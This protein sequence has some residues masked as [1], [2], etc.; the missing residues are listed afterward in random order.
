MTGLIRLTIKKTILLCTLFLC[1]LLS[2][3]CSSLLKPITPIPRSD[4]YHH[5]IIVPLFKPLRI[6]SKQNQQKIN[7]LLILS[8][9][10]IN[11]QISI[12]QSLSHLLATLPKTINYKQTHVLFSEIKQL[13][14]SQKKPNTLA[15]ILSHYS[16]K[17]TNYSNTAFVILTQ[18]NKINNASATEAERL[19]TAQ[20]NSFC[21]YVIGINNIHDNKRLIPPQY[22]GKTVS[23][24]NLGTPNKMTN[25]VEK[26]FFLTPKDHDGDGIYDHQDHCPETK[27]NTLITW[28]GCPRNSK[29][30]N[31]RYLILSNNFTQTE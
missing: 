16:S 2:T 1:V 24:E 5:K 22:C 25:F 20:D 21:L 7:H 13:K 26:I 23:S 11:D 6:N 14:K 3:G 30:S 8:D 19:L 27:K 12:N 17:K 31:S 28:D 10:S 29:T 18:W 15:S 4:I 9:D